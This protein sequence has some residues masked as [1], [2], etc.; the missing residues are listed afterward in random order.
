MADEDVTVDQEEQEV[1]EL[2]EE[3]R[4]M[5]RLKEEAELRR[6]EIGTLRQ[7]LT[8]S[9][10]RTIIDDQLHSQL[11]ERRREETVPGFRRGRVRAGVDRR[12]Q[13]L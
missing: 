2:S 4:M 10:P 1:E 3:E 5:E 6:E 13:R 11:D 12:H 7:R 9:V 8:I